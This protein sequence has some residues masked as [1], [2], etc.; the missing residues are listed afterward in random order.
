MSATNEPFVSVEDLAKHF[1]VS[2]S[3]ARAWERQGL[4]PRHTYIKM[5]NTY[6]YCI[7]LIVEALTTAPL[8]EET[9]TPALDTPASDAPA[10]D[11]TPVQMELDFANPDADA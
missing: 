7:P 1:S 4:I 5:N 6:R 8:T 10:A 9:D 11:G 3:T 2:I